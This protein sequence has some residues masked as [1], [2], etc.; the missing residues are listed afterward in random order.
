MSASNL[1]TGDAESAL[2]QLKHG[3]TGIA[4]AAIP[5]PVPDF[6]EHIPVT[7]PPWSGSRP[8]NSPSDAP[9]LDIAPP[10]APF[11]I[12]ICVNRKRQGVI[13]GAFMQTAHAFA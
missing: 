9:P 10:L 11:T 2:G 13:T 5:S 7:T 3:D 1:K 8:K 12:G 6:I 4:I